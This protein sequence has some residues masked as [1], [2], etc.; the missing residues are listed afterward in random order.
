MRDNWNVTVTLQHSFLVFF[1]VFFFLLFLLTSQKTLCYS[2]KCAIVESYAI[3]LRKN[4][5]K[6]QFSLDFQEF[7]G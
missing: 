2:K 7:S 1:L 4:Q 3:K 5:L 6:T